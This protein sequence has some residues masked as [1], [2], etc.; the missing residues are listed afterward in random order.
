MMHRCD[1]F[2]WWKP[3]LGRSR[4][5]AADGTVSNCG[6][7]SNVK[8]VLQV[9]TWKFPASTSIR[10]VDECRPAVKIYFSVLS[11]T[12]PASGHHRRKLKADRCVI[13]GEHINFLLI[14]SH[15]D[16]SFPHFHAI[17]TKTFY[18]ENAFTVQIASPR[19]FAATAWVKT[20]KL[21]FLSIVATWLKLIWMIFDFFFSLFL[22]A[23]PTIDKSTITLTQFAGQWVTM[24]TSRRVEVNSTCVR[25]MRSRFVRISIT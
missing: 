21:S 25:A 10:T 13:I 9:D 4:L 15:R 7:Y 5:L 8:Y 3:D 16:V 18:R 11:P 6:I 1:S 23:I 19:R 22:F 2:E 24:L 17:A 20:C 12:L 14:P